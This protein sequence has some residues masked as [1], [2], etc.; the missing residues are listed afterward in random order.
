M[1][2]IY[3]GDSEEIENPA[4]PLEFDL[5]PGPDQISKLRIRFLTATEL[6]SGKLL[7]EKPDFRI[8]LS[9]ARDRISTL[10]ALYQ[11]G[12]LMIDFKGMGQHA[13]A[14]NMTRCD[15]EWRDIMRK[16]SRTGQTHPL[17]GFVGE[18]EYEGNL[19]EFV[20]FLRAAQWTGVGRHT[21][22][23]KGFIQLSIP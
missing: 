15:V 21:V 17:G 1:K 8:L 22:W 2:Q 19:A 10:Q 20:P 23:G 9:R 6:K 13:K 16:S 11:S 18:A 5:K 3:S 4:P 12:P 7:A 14:V